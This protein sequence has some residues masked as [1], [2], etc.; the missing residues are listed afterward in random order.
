MMKGCPLTAVMRWS[1][2]EGVVKMMAWILRQ[3]VWH[4]YGLRRAREGAEQRRR[5]RHALGHSQRW[6]HSQT[7]AERPPRPRRVWQPQSGRS[8]AQSPHVRPTPQGEASM[9]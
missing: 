6:S 7:A 2:M 9:Q 5:W 1:V 8:T 3:K 4:A